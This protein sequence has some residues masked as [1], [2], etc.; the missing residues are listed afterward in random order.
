MG[1][2]NTNG[3]KWLQG[4]AWAFPRFDLDCLTLFPLVSLS[5]LILLP[6]AK[7][8]IWTFGVLSLL[9]LALTLWQATA[10]PT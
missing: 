3:Y 2:M 9:L 6:D 1:Y 10:G 5:P 8:K 4:V 7:V